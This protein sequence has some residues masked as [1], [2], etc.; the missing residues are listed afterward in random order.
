MHRNEEIA[1]ATTAGSQEKTFA[2]AGMRA[3]ILAEHSRRWEDLTAPL[4]RFGMRFDIFDSTVEGLAAVNLAGRNGSAYKIVMI[5]RH[6]Q[7]VDAAVLGGAIR[8]NP[9]HREALLV[10]LD[11]ANGDARPGLPGGGFSASLRTS[12]SGAEFEATLA[13]LCMSASG[14]PSPVGL[15]D[16]R[17]DGEISSAH[18]GYNILVAD[19]NLVNQQVAARML[20]K[21]GCK[22]AVAADGMQAVKMHTLTPFDLILMDCEMPVLDGLEATQRIRA[23]EG[24]ARRTPIIALTACTGQGEK[25]RCLAAG[26]DDFL[27]KPIRPQM[28]G[29]VL[30][31]WLARPA[32]S[33]VADSACE[34]ELEE[35][36]AMFGAD[37][38]ELAS[39]YQNDGGPRL[40]AMREAAAI[41]DCAKVAKVAHA[42]GGSCAS[43]GATGLAALSKTVETAAKAGSLESFDQRMAGI[44]NEYRRVCGKLQS[45]LTQ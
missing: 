22:A 39:L 3:L 5:E 21:L 6:L 26:M 44:E 45:L 34:D 13:S 30:A 37:F 33:T 25:E 35:V 2:M 16:R 10:M 1:A 14:A 32:A 31:R 8:S 43:I 20:E 29:D 27:S 38:A 7:G 12:A 19:D 4:A 11:S 36:K 18:S 9:G 15:P 28:L 23:A 40:A 41:G 24:T 17:A 42:F